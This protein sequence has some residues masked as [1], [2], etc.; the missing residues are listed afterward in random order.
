MITLLHSLVRGGSPLPP[1][2][3]AL[4][5]GVTL[6]LQVTRVVQLPDRTRTIYHPFGLAPARQKPAAQWDLLPDEPV[7]HQVIA[8]DREVIFLQ[9]ALFH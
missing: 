2:P 5:Q 4:S 8:M 7:P 9:A 1:A 6:A 3:P